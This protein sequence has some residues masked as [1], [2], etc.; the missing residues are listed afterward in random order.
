MYFLHFDFGVHT[1]GEGEVLEGFD[2][3]GGGVHNVNQAFVNFHL[4][5]FAAGLV[6]VGGFDDGEG[7]AFGGERDGATDGSAGPDSSIDDLFG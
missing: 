1:S 4:K 7:R 6:D 5:G 2:G 3:F